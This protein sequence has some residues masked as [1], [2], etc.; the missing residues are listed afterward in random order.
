MISLKE[1][2]I[3]NKLKPG[4]IG[5]VTY[6]HGTLYKQEYGYGVDFEAYVAKGLYHFFTNYQEDKDCV[7]VC[8]YDQKIVGFM[9][10]MNRGQAAQLRYFIIHPDYRGIGLG[11]KLMELYLQF[12]NRAGYDSAYL[13]T[14]PDLEAATHLY[15]KFGFSLVEEIRPGLFKKPELLQKYELIV[16]S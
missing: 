1:I 7:W 4:D 12:L 9:A 13:L 15:R 10:L 5:Y 14:S 2:S 3:R 6:L 8:E 11:N 16:T